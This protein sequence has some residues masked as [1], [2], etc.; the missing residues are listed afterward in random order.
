MLMQGARSGHVGQS[1]R[2]A[3]RLGHRRVELP[4]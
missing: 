3:D 1:A 2:S 4:S